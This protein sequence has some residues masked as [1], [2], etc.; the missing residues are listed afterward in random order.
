M[1]FT[2]VE[3]A[4]ARLNRS[5]LAVPGS[6]PKLF[7]KLYDEKNVNNPYITA[8]P[9]RILTNI[10]AAALKIRSGSSYRVAL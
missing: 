6:N 8:M 1:S 2:I 7:S 9:T 10:V 5:E 4:T 3:Q